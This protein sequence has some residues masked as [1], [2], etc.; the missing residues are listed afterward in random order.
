MSR[1]SPL[2]AI[3]LNDH[4]AGAT[5]GLE[6]FRRA[7][8]S[9][10]APAKAEL[11]RLVVEVQQDRESLLGFM[12]ALGVPVQ[13]Y[14]VL[15]GWVAE[16]AGRVK[17]NGH[18]WSRSPLSDLVELEALVLGVNGKAAGLRALQTV[19][20]DDPRLDAAELDR[21]VARAERQSVTLEG[22]RLQAAR[23]ALAAGDPTARA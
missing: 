4:L 14:K 11:E 18:L 9:H 8:R 22:L 2:L 16:K 1:T 20:E 7:A 13:R 3:Y 10:P 17:P 19:A 23:R 5:A 6:L 12:R 21:L 15:G